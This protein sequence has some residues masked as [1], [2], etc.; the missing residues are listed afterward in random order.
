MKKN[1][2]NKNNFKFNITNNISNF[3]KYIDSFTLPLKTLPKIKNT[4]LY[5]ELINFL[6]VNLIYFYEAKNNPMKIQN[7]VL[8]NILKNNKN[9]LYGKKNNFNKIKSIKEFQE[10]VPIVNYENLLTY[11]NKIKKGEKNI[12]TKDKVIFFATTSGTTKST[13]PKL[14]PITKKR[15]INFRKE[16]LLWLLHV[17]KKNPSVVKHKTLYFAGPPDEFLLDIGIP[18]GSIS[19]YHVKKLP[20]FLK[21]KI[22]VPWKIYNIKD[23]DEKIKKIALLSLKNKIS[24]IAFASPIEAILFFNY[25][26]QNK[27]Q[28]IDEL[29]KQ[30]KI[31]LA[32]SLSKKEFTPNKLWPE[33][34]L[35]SCIMS[36]SNKFYIDKLKKIIG[37]EIM[38]RDPGIYAS[39]G[40]IS[41]CI[42]DDGIS[43]IPVIHYNFFEFIEINNDKKFNINKKNKVLTVDQLKINKLYRVLMTT[44]EGLYRYDIGDII[45]VVGF[46][47][48]LPLIVFHD[49]DNF[50]NIVGE[51]A[52]ENVIVEAVNKTIHHYKINVKGF[53]LI[54]S[55][56]GT[57]PRYEILIEIENYKNLKIINEFRK[58]I[59]KN[60]QEFIS[61]YKQMRNEFGRMQILVL[62]IVKKGS[63][64]KINKDHLTRSG[65]PKPI[66]INKDP[67]FRN[68][69]EIIKTFE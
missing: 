18:C 2:L 22:V 31:K 23:F 10:K 64:D 59:D 27:S 4:I 41:L 54:P 25:I 5:R 34:S 16:I 39:E 40:R 32:N 69:F 65:Q 1:K 47:N 43:A 42:A 26:K 62:S 60:L 30:K 38:I 46:L 29:K 61:D 21:H 15:L 13:E 44:S 56:T 55:F 6:N 50:L 14:I 8:I 28:L 33:L 11:I 37:K 7:K 19:G 35:I 66:N 49:R 24:Q 51:L 52:H 3:K 20:F 57:K 45:K 63:F 53:T 12:L 48:K 67:N 17:I 58:E 36:N 68:K 9:T